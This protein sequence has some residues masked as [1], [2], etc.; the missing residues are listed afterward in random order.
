MNEIRI[1]SAGL[2]AGLVDEF[3]FLYRHAPRSTAPSS[4]RPQTPAIKGMPDDSRIALTV[5]RVSTSLPETPSA[6]RKAV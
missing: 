4:R 6:R 3:P 2:L 1:F 5:P